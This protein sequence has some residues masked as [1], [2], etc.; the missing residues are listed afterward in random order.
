MPTGHS[1]VISTNISH[2]LEAATPC[3]QPRP[4]KCPQAGHCFKKPWMRATENI[5]KTISGCWSRLEELGKAVQRNLISKASL[6]IRTY[7]LESWP[8]LKNG[9]SVIKQRCTI[10]VWLTLIT[11]VVGGVGLRYTDMSTKLAVWTATKDFYELC[12]SQNVSF[13]KVPQHVSFC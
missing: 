8:K 13:E 2:T 3:P 6:K 1:T 10:S 11:L 7:S 4:S 5:R 9:L 12:Q